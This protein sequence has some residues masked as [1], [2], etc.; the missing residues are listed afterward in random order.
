MNHRDL[1]P[2]TVR[3]STLNRIKAGQAVRLYADLLFI[4]PFLAYLAAKGSVTKADRQA[5][6]WIGWTT[7]AYNGFNFLRYL[8]HPSEGSS[9]ALIPDAILPANQTYSV[10]TS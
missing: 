8:N 1:L 2:V 7:L 9:T 5:L 4:A 10:E 3:Q 6:L